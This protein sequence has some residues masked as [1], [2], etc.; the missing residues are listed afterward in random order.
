MMLMVCRCTQYR[1]VR[2]YVV[3]VG[4]PSSH[5]V[6]VTDSTPIYDLGLGTRG[7]SL[8]SET[9]AQKQGNSTVDHKLRKQGCSV[10]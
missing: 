10:P 4:S 1:R 2:Q 5:P 3:G 8:T 9:R 7:S 6:T